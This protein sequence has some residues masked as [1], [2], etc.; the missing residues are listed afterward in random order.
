M[1][2]ISGDTMAAIEA[3]T[4][5]WLGAVR[6]MEAATREYEAARAA[7]DQVRRRVETGAGIGVPIP[8]VRRSTSSATSQPGKVMVFLARG[9]EHSP[10]DVATGADVPL[11]STRAVL[12]L[13]KERGFC[14]NPAAGRWRAVAAVPAAIPDAPV[15]M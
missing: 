3:A 10:A 4:Q 12:T 15:E 13:L 14:E 11:K 1:K 5:R 6:A 7:L 2:M 8:R 9:G